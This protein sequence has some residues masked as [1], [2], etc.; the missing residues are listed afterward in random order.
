MLNDCKSRIGTDAANDDWRLWEFTRD[1]RIPHG[2]FDTP[3]FDI[4]AAI[5]IV[6]TGIVVGI[7]AC[8][9]GNFIN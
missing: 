5:V 3:R 7:I 9:V 2:T 4:N 1:S 8:V 6:C